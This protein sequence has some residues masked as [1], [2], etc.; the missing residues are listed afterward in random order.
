MEGESDQAITAY[1]T[2]ARKF[3]QSHLAKLFIGMEHLH[4]GNLSLARL[5]LDGS[6]EQE[7]NDPL[8][9][10]ERGVVAYWKE[11]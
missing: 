4:Q 5:F 7:P 10:S 3:Q 8:C 11:E 9:L 1:S 2:A 6:A